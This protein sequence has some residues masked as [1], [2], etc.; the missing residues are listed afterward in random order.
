MRQ[1]SCSEP[2]G[3]SPNWAGANHGRWSRP[4]RR[5][6]VCRARRRSLNLTALWML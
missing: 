4:A 1:L 6:V 5:T 2:S 3:L